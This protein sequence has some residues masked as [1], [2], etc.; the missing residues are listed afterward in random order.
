MDTRLKA[1]IEALDQALVR[2]SA[3]QCRFCEHC[4]G[5]I[6]DG[7]LQALPAMT[8]FVACAQAERR[9]VHN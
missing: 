1:Q 8:L 2:F 5:E 4:R 9:R 7:R 6:S 3:G